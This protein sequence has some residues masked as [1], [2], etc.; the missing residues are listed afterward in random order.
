MKRNLLSPVFAAMVGLLLLVICI[1]SFGAAGNS[2]PRFASEYSAAISDAGEARFLSRDAIAMTDTRNMKGFS[3]HFGTD[4]AV[5]SKGIALLKELGVKYVRNGTTW[6]RVET[7]K[8]VYNFSSSDRWVQE[9]TDAGIGII[10]TLLYNNTLYNADATGI[11]KPGP[12]T[13]AEFDAFVQYAVETA[14]R[15]PQITNYEIWNEPNH[16]G[17][18]QPSGDYTNYAKLVRQTAKALKAVN[19][20]IKVVVGSVATGGSLTPSD[21]G[22]YLR[23]MMSEGSYPYIDA[24]SYHPYVF[25]NTIEQNSGKLQWHHDNVAEIIRDYGGFKSMMVTEVGWPTSVNSEGVTEEVQARELVKQYITGDENGIEANMI[26]DFRNDGTDPNEREHNFGVV[27]NDFTLKKSFYSI[28]TYFDFTSDADYVGKLDTSDIGNGITAHVYSK[29]GEPVIVAWKPAGDESNIAVN[30]TSVNAYDMY[31]EN[32]EVSTESAETID[33]WQGPM[34]DNTKANLVWATDSVGMRSVLSSPEENVFQLADGTAAEKEKK[35]ILIDEDPSAENT[36]SKYFILTYQGYGGRRF[37]TASTA[38]ANQQKYDMEST[39]NIAYWLNDTSAAG[40]LGTSG[41]GTQNG[42]EYKL[43][44]AIKNG[45]NYSHIWTTEP[46]EAGRMRAPYTVTG[47]VSLISAAEFKHYVNKIGRWESTDT[48]GVSYG[49]ASYNN[50]P[51]FW[52]SRSARGGT[53]NQLSISRPDVDNGGRI[54]INSMWNNTG[55]VR[56]VFWLKG[57]FFKTNKID[58]ATAGANVKLIVKGLYDA[59][60]TTPGLYTESDFSPSSPGEQ[61]PVHPESNLSASLPIGQKPVYITGADK[62]Y[63]IKAAASHTEERLL[64]FLTK[65][66]VLLSSAAEVKSAAESLRTDIHKLKANGTVQD[67]EIRAKL[68]TLYALG[69]GLIAARNEGSLDCT[70]LQLNTMLTDID[71]VG[72]SL[73]NSLYFV[74]GTSVSFEAGNEVL[75]KVGANLEMLNSEDDSFPRAI[76]NIALSERLRGLKIQSDVDYPKRASRLAILEVRSAKLVSWVDSIVSLLAGDG[77]V[78]P[79]INLTVDNATGLLTLYGNA[80]RSG[81]NITAQ[82]LKPG[83]SVAQLESETGSLQDGL[84]FFAQTVTG[85]DGTFSFSYTMKGLSGVYTLRLLTPYLPDP[86]EK[87][88]TLDRGEVF[89]PSSVVWTNDSGQTAL[90]MPSAGDRLNLDITALNPDILNVPVLIL[91]CYSESGVMREVKLGTAVSSD[92]SLTLHAD[93]IAPSNNLIYKWFLWKD[94]GTIIPID[95]GEFPINP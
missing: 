16:N 9:L 22:M 62:A 25:P 85:S 29:D 86:Y 24:I 59:S 72:R 35:F 44:T 14:R 23:G 88:F 30:G 8:G 83:I 52:L 75:E 69:D 66:S 2:F 49:Y 84:D 41:N 27:K 1:V 65:N 12:T 92:G 91:A 94:M 17:F 15:Y 54:V 51:Q 39:T 33:E 77:G 60:L 87:I 50:A 5:N 37:D 73:A 53:D 70:A 4:Y 19:P 89:T 81:V 36:D 95:M 80:R 47:G 78:K 63:F 34:Y 40:F 18:W 71:S 57:D 10:F 26:Y 68:D 21:Y 31:G 61:N 45:I 74:E 11:N 3:T 13:Q 58:L 56:P 6:A 55:I 67:A 38:P 79:Y 82:V 90:S 48:N 7:T 76:F 43:P 28:K 20:N 46:T 32:I 42:K 64:M 93:I